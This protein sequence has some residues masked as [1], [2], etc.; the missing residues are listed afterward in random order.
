LDAL[1]EVPGWRTL[2][3]QQLPPGSPLITARPPARA[4]WADQVEP[5]EA[6]QVLALADTLEDTVPRRMVR[7][8]RY[9]REKAEDRGEL[10]FVSADPDSA[11]E[12]LDALVALHRRRWGGDGV[13]D[14][15][16][17][18]MLREA[19]PALARAGRLRLHG[20][21]VGGATAAVLYG[22]ADP[23]RTSLYLAGFDPELAELGIGKLLIGH[24]IERAIAEGHREVDFLRGDEGHKRLWGA[25]SRP[26]LHRIL[27]RPA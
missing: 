6:C 24:A 25:T 12:L 7:N 10:V 5:G 15:R 18:A 26:M 1:E 20:L 19:T 8:L 23:R 14:P 9:Y 17:V 22:L 2:D 3:L 13:L 21:R 4:A 27:R 16:A 11:G